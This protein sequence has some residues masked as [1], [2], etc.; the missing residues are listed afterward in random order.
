MADHDHVNQTHKII[1]DVFSAVH[2]RGLLLDVS[3]M[4]NMSHILC[5]IVTI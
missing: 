4:S 3:Y 1:S 5:V 2:P